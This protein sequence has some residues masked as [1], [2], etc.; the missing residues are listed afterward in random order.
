[1]NSKLLKVIGLSIGGL[2][3]LCVAQQLLKYRSCVNAAEQDRDEFDPIDEASAESFP[4]SD[5]PARTT[6]SRSGGW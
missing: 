2:G 3:L 4:A 5:P 1:M 6:I